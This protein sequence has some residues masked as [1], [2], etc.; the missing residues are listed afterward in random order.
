M[1]GERRKLADTLFILRWTIPGVILALVAAHQTAQFLIAGA[2]SPALQFAAN[3]LIYGVG[4]AAAAWL[5]LTLMARGVVERERATAEAR[6]REQYL[7]SITTESADA[8][9]SLD[10][11]GAIQSWSRGAEH[12]FGYTS[13][14]VVGKHFGILVPDDLKAQHEIERLGEMVAA[15]GFIRNYETE[16]LTK[17]GQRVNVDITR[18]LITDRD[19][20]VVG[21]S[22]IMRD[23]TARKRAEAESRQLNR[24]LEERVVQRTRELEQASQELRQRNADLERANQELQ[25]LDR[26]K[27]DFYSM[28]SHELRAPL[29]NI[30][31]ALELMNALPAT[32]GSAPS[33]ALLHIVADQA[34]RLTRFVQSVLNVTRIEANGLSLRL[35]AVD[36][37]QLMT[38]VSSD[39]AARSVAHHIIVAGQ[40][41]LSPVW[42][43][44]ERIEEVLTNLVDNAIKYSPQGGAITLSASAQAGQ[45][46][47]GAR[48][49][50]VS[51]S[52]QGIGI[53]PAD[54]PHIFERFYRVDRHDSHEVYGHG[55]GLYITRKLIEAHGGCIWVES[56]PGRGSCF[57][58]TLPAAPAAAPEPGHD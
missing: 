26:L 54:Q 15:S 33:P 22:A 50:V 5:T 20:R 13:S 53:A 7:A 6:Q 57:F 10:T 25:A 29:T 48:F 14:D 58:F 56:A 12:I 31:G 9:L 44:H 38:K 39:F 52:D 40:P 8:I 24:V 34:A 55:L 51:V 46:P 28:V 11:D 45:L 43:D 49:I 41:P 42:A 17:T 23:I 35:A 19:G 2:I 16:R 21:F 27:S 4:G 47:D 1:L 3:V 37:G 18:T 30:N 36:I 32:D